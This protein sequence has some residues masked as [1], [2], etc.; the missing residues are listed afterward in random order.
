[1]ELTLW[2]VEEKDWQG[3]WS[4][5]YGPYVDKFRAETKA[6]KIDAASGWHHREPKTRVNGI[7]IK[8]EEA[9]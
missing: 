5:E 8:G 7:T 6:R 4:P 3:N 2:W 9:Y 1:M